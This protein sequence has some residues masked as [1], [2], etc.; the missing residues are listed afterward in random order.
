MTEY[1]GYS[2]TDLYLVAALLSR[3]HPLL[4]TERKGRRVYFLMEDT[5]ELRANI[6]DYFGGRLSVDALDFSNQVKSAK[7]II[8]NT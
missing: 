6:G 2:S 3:G 8:Y 1:V 7:A 5:P 4:G